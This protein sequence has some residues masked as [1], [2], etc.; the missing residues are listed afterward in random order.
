VLLE[1]Y[2]YFKTSRRDGTKTDQEDIDELTAQIAS[3]AGIQDLMP[4]Q[5]FIAV[6]EE[7]ITDNDD[8]II[9]SVVDMYSMMRR[10]KCQSLKERYRGSKSL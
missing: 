2:S 1:V 8:D 10:A 3:L 4:V 5:E 7:V 9:A 6:L